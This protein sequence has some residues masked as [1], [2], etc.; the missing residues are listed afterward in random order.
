M[1]IPAREHGESPVICR[2][3]RQQ[4][5]V[6]DIDGRHDRRDLPD[7]LHGCEAAGEKRGI[8][9]G[10]ARQQQRRHCGGDWGRGGGGGIFRG[11]WGERRH[12]L[13]GGRDTTPDA[14]QLG[15]QG[16]LPVNRWM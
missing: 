1:Y 7:G 12:D 3:F 8:G 11:D 13:E 4:R 6:G 9:R 5:G 2:R 15:Q 16:A 14:V 10:V